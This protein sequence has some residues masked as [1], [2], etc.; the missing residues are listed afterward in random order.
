VSDRAGRYC[1]LAGFPEDHRA[2]ATLGALLE[3]SDRIPSQHRL[4]LT[5]NQRR[6][7]ARRADLEAP[8]GIETY[9]AEPH[10]PWQRPTNENCNALLRRYVGK[11]TGLGVYGPGDLRAIATPITT[12]PRPILASSTAHTSYTTAVAITV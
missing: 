2:E 9:F 1:W 11:S 3:I 10:H 5:W 6:E 12:M 8:C 4:T 7:T